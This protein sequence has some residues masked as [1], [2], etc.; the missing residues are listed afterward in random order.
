MGHLRLQEFGAG[1][2]A[3]LV[4]NATAIRVLGPW[5][6]E[7]DDVNLFDEC[8]AKKRSNELPTCASTRPEYQS[9]PGG[10]C[11]ANQGDNKW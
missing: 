1:C 7:F 3:V 4:S 2:R 8:K 5:L 6:G 10:V 9:R 11:H